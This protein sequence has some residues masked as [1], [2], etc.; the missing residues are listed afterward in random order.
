MCHCI[1]F[2]INPR[3]SKHHAF[4]HHRM[5]WWQLGL[6]SKEDIC[7]SLCQLL[8]EC[9]QGRPLS[10]SQQSYNIDII[11]MRE[12]VCS[13]EE[14]HCGSARSTA[15]DGGISD[16]R[17]SLRLY[18]SF[19]GENRSCQWLLESFDLGSLCWLTFGRKSTGWREISSRLA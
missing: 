11:F 6:S 16:T 2:G 5:T 9:W 17:T 19:K 8:V 14:V 1:F 7:V 12:Q 13:S 10:D 15:G 4:R 3:V 18:R